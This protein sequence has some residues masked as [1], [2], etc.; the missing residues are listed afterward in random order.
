MLGL[1]GNGCIVNLEGVR[2]SYVHAAAFLS[3]RLGQNLDCCLK[4][5]VRGGGEAEKPNC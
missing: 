5:I 4:M 2:Q 1:C 3:L